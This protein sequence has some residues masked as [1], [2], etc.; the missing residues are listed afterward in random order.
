MKPLPRK[1]NFRALYPVNSIFEDKIENK[2]P[3]RF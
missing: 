3:K 2:N 1:P